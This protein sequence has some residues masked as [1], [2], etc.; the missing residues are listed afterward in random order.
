M[1]ML[2]SNVATSLANH[3][4][5]IPEDSIPLIFSMIPFKFLGEIEDMKSDQKRQH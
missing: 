2:P 3:M 1:N 5:S 4:V